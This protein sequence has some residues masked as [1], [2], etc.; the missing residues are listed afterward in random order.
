MH[1]LMT[2]ENNSIIDAVS[3]DKETGEVRLS[4][5]DHHP[6]DTARLRLL[7]DKIDLN[8]G[9]VESAKSMH[10]AFPYGRR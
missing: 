1:H 6:W 7:Q 10:S 8:L 9:F 2:V 4:I 3:T 5:F